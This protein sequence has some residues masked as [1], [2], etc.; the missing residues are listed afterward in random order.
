VGDYPEDHGSS[1]HP[2]PDQFPINGFARVVG[3][4]PTGIG[5]VVKETRTSSY[6]NARSFTTSV[7]ARGITTAKFSFLVPDGGYQVTASVSGPSCSGGRWIRGK[8]K[9]G[10]VSASRS[11]PT[12]FFLYVTPERESV[13]DMQLTLALVNGLLP[14]AA[15]ALYLHN[16]GPQ[17]DSSRWLANASS[18]EYTVPLSQPPRTEKACFSLEEIRFPAGKEEFGV[19]KYYVIDLSSLPANRQPKAIEWDPAQYRIHLALNFEDSGIELKGYYHGALG[20][21]DSL[22][23]DVDLTGPLSVEAFLA[24]TFYYWD[25]RIYYY[26]DSTDFKV[27]SIDATGICDLGW[28]ACE[29]VFHYKEEI[30]SRVKSELASVLSG[31]TVAEG[32]AKGM[33]AIINPTAGAFVTEMR[34]EGG[35]LKVKWVATLKPTAAAVTTSASPVSNTTCPPTVAP[36]HGDQCGTAQGGAPRYCPVNH[37]CCDDVTFTCIPKNIPRYACP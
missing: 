37:K 29:A 24:P 21:S 2:P 36:A 11:F 1:T 10:T 4:T 28:D 12:I 15:P 22:A 23:P 32:L 34:K 20:L 33:E 27:K 6:F 13:L 26:P 31:G 30:K 9:T 7:D 3:C 17:H 8:E 5:I 25:G 35:A 14:S 19:F 18:F 16:H